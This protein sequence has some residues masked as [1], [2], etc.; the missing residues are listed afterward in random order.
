VRANLEL[1]AAHSAR[2]PTLAPDLSS[3]RRSKSGAEGKEAGR[4]EERSVPCEFPLRALL[5]IFGA[6]LA[7]GKAS[8]LS[9]ERNN[10]KIKVLALVSAA[11]SLDGF[12][13]PFRCWQRAAG[14]SSPS[15]ALI[16]IF[17]RSARQII[18]N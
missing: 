4:G 16:W 5:S 14:S 17:I 3:S 7:Y 13:P 15:C 10:V 6:I 9:T 2:L 12:K 11:P 18:I 1:S 8:P